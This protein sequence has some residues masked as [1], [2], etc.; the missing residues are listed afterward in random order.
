MRL[1]FFTVLAVS[2][3][4][5]ATTSSTSKGDPAEEVLDQYTDDVQIEDLVQGSGDAAA[6]GNTLTVHYTGWL[7]SGARFDTSEGKEPLTFKLGARRVIK[8]W[9]QGLVG[10]KVGGKR[11]L[12]IPPKLGYGSKASG[13]I[14]PDSRLIFE[15]QLLKLEK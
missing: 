15:V 11:K 5:C 6:A 7:V 10:L 9:D 1:F 14:P 8:G 3:L 12:I 4:G 2:G 13:D